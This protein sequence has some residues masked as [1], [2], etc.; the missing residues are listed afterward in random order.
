MLLLHAFPI[1]LTLMFL[2]LKVMLLLAGIIVIFVVVLRRRP[3]PSVSQA[4]A[5]RP[6][7]APEPQPPARTPAEPMRAAAMLQP[8]AR[9]SATAPHGRQ[10]APAL[11]AL[12]LVFPELE[13]QSLIGQGGM[14]A[15][16]R[17]RRLADGA[18]LALKVVAAEGAHGQDFAA[19]FQQETQALRRLDHPG[20]V[21][22]RDFGRSGPWCWLLMDF[23]DGANL[24]QVVATGALSPKQTLAL[25]GP[26]CAALQYAHD[27]AIVHRD[28]KPENILV[29]AQGA[30]HLVDFGMAKIGE[31]GEAL[32]AS[33]IALGTVHYMAPEQ[34]ESSRVVDQRA[35]I[36]SLGVILYELL[37]GRL[38]LGRF[39]PPSQRVPVDARIDE[40]VMRALERDPDRR[41]QR[42]SQIADALRAIAAQPAPAPVPPA[43]RNPGAA[44]VPASATAVVRP[45]G[46]EVNTFTMLLHLALF[47]GYLIPCAGFILTIIMWVTCRDLD[48]RIDVHGRIAVNWIISAFIYAVL[49][50]LLCFVLIG[51]PLLIVLALI[52]LIFPII[53]SIKASQGEVWEYPCSIRF[54]G[55][56]PA[57]ASRAGA[58]S[59]L[60]LGCLGVGLLFVLLVV[61]AFALLFTGRVVNAVAS[62]PLRNI[63]VQ[64][65]SP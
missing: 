42:I 23:V 30:P 61:G 15:V 12:Q 53:G 44:A 2:L 25:M 57:S 36:Y 8:A 1:S 5:P 24:R 45:W 27:Q 39:E 54:L 13:I 21:A 31:S 35:D 58:G 50:I 59:V 52:G 47:A 37:T 60:T 11:A 49:S 18:I 34:V 40:V 64:T 55:T 3:G 48:P 56:P 4:P 32:T 51:I 33:G 7:P 43:A 29:D 17:V 26:L 20:I 63:S 28:L 9:T 22:I 10:P 62:S 41:W 16:Y 6:D 14:G 65:T 19:R 38:P 46:M